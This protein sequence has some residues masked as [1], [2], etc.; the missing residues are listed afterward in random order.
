[1]ATLVIQSAPQ[2]DSLL[3]V[4]LDRCSDHFPFDLYFS[5]CK[6]RFAE[7]NGNEMPTTEKFLEKWAAVRPEEALSCECH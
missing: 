6:D 4:I 3:Y 5:V 2:L 1:L 7:F